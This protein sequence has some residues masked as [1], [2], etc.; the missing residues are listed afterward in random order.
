MQIFVK[1]LTGKT[2]TLEVE[3][4]DSIENVKAKIQDKEGIPPDQQRL[5]FAGKQL[6]DGRT[7]SDYNIQ[8]ESTLHLVLR[9]RGG[10]ESSDIEK[11]DSVSVDDVELLSSKDMGVKDLSGPPVSEPSPE[12]QGV[13][14]DAEED[15]E[16]V[17]DVEKVKEEMFTKKCKLVLKKDDVGGFIGAKGS[18]LMKFVINKTQSV[19]DDGVD[20]YCRITR[21]T[22]GESDVYFALIRASTEEALE[23]L[24]KNVYLHQKAFL[25]RKEKMIGRPS[26]KYVFKCSME[27][28]KIAKFIGSKGR[29][30]NELIE[31]IRVSDN[32]LLG[33]GPRI[34]IT[35]DRKIRMNRLHF[36]HL[37][38]DKELDEKVLVT[39]E[40]DTK[41]RSASLLIVRDF[42]KQ[43]V[44]KAS[45]DSF[46]VGRSSGGEYSHEGFNDD[47]DPNDW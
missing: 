11:T 18:K 6:E 8:K 12:E 27:N 1:T 14:D 21:L 13:F 24:E 35:E 39:V 30:I 22:E 7:L 16:E 17:K 23:I 20:V 28:H 3:G 2:I 9:L 45:M 41:D 15:V 36:E 44:E 19:V 26:T 34:S 38:M 5:I 33:D 43:A 37:K 25:G 32:N 47:I 29:N 31:A 10:G 46:N 40:L 4:S 42:V